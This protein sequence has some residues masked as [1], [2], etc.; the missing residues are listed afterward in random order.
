L[1]IAERL[2][3]SGLIRT[4]PLDFALRLTLL[5][6]LLRPVGDG[7]VRAGM[8]VLAVLALGVRGGLRRPA[9]WIAM[10]GLAALRVIL[11]WELAD[12]HAYLLAYWL[13]AI[14]LALGGRNPEG[15]LAA[16]A[17]CLVGLVFLLACVWKGLLSPDY[18]DGRVFSLFLILDPRFEPIARIA[19]G[20]DLEQLE[21]LRAFLR[22]H[23]DLVT[24]L[25]GGPE[26]PRRLAL[27]AR[28]LTYWT[29]G[30][31][32]ATAL[33]FLWPRPAAAMRRWRD[34]LLLAFCATTYPA[35]GI[36]SFGWLLLAMG[37]AQCEPARTPTRLGYLAVFALLVVTRAL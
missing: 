7:P 31:E 33:A 16:S 14:G 34:A 23:A 36:E 21:A 19:G 29:L 6:L 1:R 15:D 22:T 30:I 35:V 10:A 9:I 8:L 13:A 12:N 2:A 24:A 26:I 28:S 37:A 5:A 20:V 18:L 11:D 4:P 27:V 32:L 17:R 25:P 3:P